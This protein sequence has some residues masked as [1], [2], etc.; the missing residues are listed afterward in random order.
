MFPAPLEV[1]RYLYRQ[2]RVGFPRLWVQVTGSFRGRQG[3]IPF[4]RAYAYRTRRRKLGFRPLSR[5]IGIY[6]LVFLCSIRCFLRSSFRPLSRQ[7]GSYT[8]QVENGMNNSDVL[9]P[10]PLEVDRYLYLQSMSGYQARL[11]SFRP[12]SRQIGIYT[13]FLKTLLKSKSVSGP[14]RGRQVA[15][16]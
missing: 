13:E 12:L 7:I 2:L 10:A 6:T 14:S 1:D 3:S 4:H 11:K 8:K 9:F 16:R 5:Q 15:I